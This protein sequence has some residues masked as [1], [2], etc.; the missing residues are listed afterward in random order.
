MTA[1]IA[2]NSRVRVW[3]TGSLHRVLTSMTSYH[4]PT[5]LSLST[6]VTTTSSSDTAGTTAFRLYVPCAP[7]AVAPHQSNQLTPPSILYSSNHLL[8][9]NKPAGWLSVPNQRKDEDEPTVTDNHHHNNN[10]NNNN[11]DDDKCLLT[12]LQQQRYGGGSQHTFLLPCHRLDQPCTGVVLLAKTRR[13]ASRIQ[14]NW[15]SK[16]TTKA[17]TATTT[18][19]PKIRKT[20]L[21]VVESDRCRHGLYPM[22]RGTQKEGKGGEWRELQG[23]LQMPRQRGQWSRRWSDSSSSKTLRG[24][25]VT[26]IPVTDSHR[27]TVDDSNQNHDK[28][29]GRIC[30]IRYRPLLE[31]T[32]T[33]TTTNDDDDDDGRQLCLLQIQ[34]NDGARHVI[35]AL[36]AMAHCPVVGDVRYGSRPHVPM[37]QTTFHHPQRNWRSNRRGSNRGGLPDRSVALHARSLELSDQLLPSSSSSSSSGGGPIIFCAP[38]P[39]TWMSF[40]GWSEADV[41]AALLS[42]EPA[43][44]GEALI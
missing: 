12:Y 39:D 1:V 25:S 36:L 41:Q 40:F 10:N 8:I 34:T 30:S 19:D 32:T 29:K 9:V 42:E 16:A 33:T 21:C 17:T 18:M 5:T 43:M 11:I 23:I 26:M 4:S 13:M 6:T 35:R 2:R 7:P 15:S 37:A 44:K 20:Y 31:T 27:H 28:P 3:S 24:W 14:S 38:I 22:S